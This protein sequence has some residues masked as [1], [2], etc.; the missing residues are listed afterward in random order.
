MTYVSCAPATLYRDG[1]W[2]D[3]P[4]LLDALRRDDAAA[5]A[6]EPVAEI[7]PPCRY[8]RGLPALLGGSDPERAQVA[9][10]ARQT[11]ADFTTTPA[12]LL[13]RATDCCISRSVLYMLRDD[14]V[15]VLHETH[16]PNDRALAGL[17]NNDEIR[18]V[19]EYRRFDP[20][21]A[22]LWIGSAGSADYA[23]WLVD[24]LPRLAALSELRR[25]RPYAKL[26]L[27]TPDCGPV[28]NAIHAQSAGAI[29]VSLGIDDVALLG[30][31]RE[32]RIFFQELYLVT[33]VTHHPVL[34]SPDAMRFV[35]ERL[36][37]AP[38]LPDAS[39]RREPPPG[40]L[41]VPRRWTGA[42][43]LANQAEIAALLAGH[44]FVTVDVADMPVLDQAR[45]FSGAAMVI[46]CMGP[47]M[48]NTL[49]CAPGAR[50]GCLAPQGW[51]ETFFWDLAAAR[52]QR[53]A[54]CYG[55]TTPNNAP[56]WERNYRVNPADVEKLLQALSHDEPTPHRSEQT[57]D[58]FAIRG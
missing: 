27:V 18:L 53:Y 25:V 44:G 47:S 56:P 2:Y 4:A 1:G 12:V 58:P 22:Y 31:D 42:R 32:A 3:D 13:A 37:H 8:E 45:L 36:P 5:H 48:A 41:F 52:G 38:G 35:A 16:R 14:Q 43:D 33:P 10:V 15:R 28:Q 39:A 29:A 19:D 23:H 49:F 34:K 50:I 6:P 46:G 20:Y 9:A 17:R 30:V 54:A 26:V 7:F 21:V 51:V 11:E 55:L 57:F 24:D 40:R